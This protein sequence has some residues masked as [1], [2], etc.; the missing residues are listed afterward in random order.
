MSK[1]TRNVVLLVLCVFLA[2]SAIAC[3]DG[4]TLD[5][6][7]DANAALESAVDGTALDQSQ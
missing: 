7:R 5:A 6:R 4:D 3:I 1:H 2:F